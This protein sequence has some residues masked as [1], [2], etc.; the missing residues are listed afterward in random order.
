MRYPKIQSLFKREGACCTPEQIKKWTPDQKANRHR[1]TEEYSCDEFSNV[2]RWILTE[3]IDGCNLRVMCS[4]PCPRMIWQIKF[5]GRTDAAM[6]PPK[7]LEYLQ[8]HFTSERI[9]E[10]FPDSE[11]IIL[12]GEGY[13]AKI[14]NGG[15]YSAEQRFCLFDV[16]IGRRWWMDYGTVMDMANKLDIPCATVIAPKGDYSKLWEEEEIIEYV[17][18]SKDSPSSPL[19]EFAKISQCQME[20]VVARAFPMMLFRDG[21]PVKFKLKCKDFMVTK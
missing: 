20:G 19:S 11:E 1:F 13:G 12:Y 10:T 14:Q 16:V 8:G 4:R 9:E 2:K 21:T 18:G 7:L 3:K 6:L 15:Y 17:K 5:A